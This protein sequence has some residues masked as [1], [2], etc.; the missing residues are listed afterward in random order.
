MVPMFYQEKFQTIEPVHIPKESSVDFVS[1][2]ILFNQ[3]SALMSPGHRIS[4]SL[5]TTRVSSMHNW[6]LYSPSKE[7]KKM[8]E[9]MSQLNE[10]KI[11][12]EMQTEAG[13]I[14]QHL[15]VSTTNEHVDTYID[16]YAC[17]CVCVCVYIYIY[18]Y[19]CVCV[20][21]HFILRLILLILYSFFFFFFFF[22]QN[23]EV[24]GFDADVMLIALE[25]YE[26]DG[27]EPLDWI[28]NKWPDYISTVKALAVNKKHLWTPRRW[29]C[30]CP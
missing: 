7:T 3:A 21:V 1:E 19:I 2:G 14:V 5:E 29:C 25:K 26:Q 12:I 17:V 9:T 6:N 11:I 24:N 22:Y 10:K 16:V 15:R 27:M 20:C 13:K 18:I 28:K 8:S 23:A 30:E 4:K